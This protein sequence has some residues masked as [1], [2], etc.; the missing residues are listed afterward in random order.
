M[1]NVLAFHFQPERTYS[2]FTPQL[3]MEILEV[4]T[5]QV[6]RSRANPGRLHRAVHLALRNWTYAGAD[7]GGG[8]GAW[9]PLSKR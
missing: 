3:Q 1:P 9:G 6:L 2:S 8:A 4:S 7:P 5:V